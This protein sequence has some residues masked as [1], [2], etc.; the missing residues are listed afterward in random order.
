MALQDILVTIT[1]LGALGYLVLRWFFP[2]LLN[3]NK[4]KTLKDCGSGNCGC[5]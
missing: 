4:K 2:K 3:K 5:S 1:L